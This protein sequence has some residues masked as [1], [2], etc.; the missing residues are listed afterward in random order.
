LH[1]PVNADA[2]KRG[3]VT[4]DGIIVSTP[5]GEIRA[6]AGVTVI[7][8]PGVTDMFHGWEKANVNLLHPRDFDPVS[9]F[10]SYKSN[11]CQVTKA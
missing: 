9:G 7:V 8:K 5:Y 11:L 1:K 3:I 2:H 10:P 4:G 6:K